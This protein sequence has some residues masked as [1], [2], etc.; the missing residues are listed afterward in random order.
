MSF[1]SFSD[2]VPKICIDGKQNVRR[3]EQTVVCAKAVRNLDDFY[4]LVDAALAREQRLPQQ[5]F[6]KHTA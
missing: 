2:G 3:G 5:Q 4:E 1:S 6:S